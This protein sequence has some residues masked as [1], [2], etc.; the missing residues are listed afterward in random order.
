M[1]VTAAPRVERSPAWMSSSIRAGSRLTARPEQAAGFD[2]GLR[3]DRAMS[4]PIDPKSVKPLACSIW[5]QWSPH[6]VSPGFGTTTAPTS[7]R[8]GGDARSSGLPR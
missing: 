4:K 8:V 7:K 1:A 5:H 2:P 3:S 6:S